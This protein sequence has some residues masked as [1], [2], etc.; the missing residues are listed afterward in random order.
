M[1]GLGMSAPNPL[2]STLRY[3]R[4]EYLDYVNIRFRS[5]LFEEEYGKDPV[6]I[7]DKKFEVEVG[8]TVLDVPREQ[9][10]YS[11]DVSF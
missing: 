3:F 6:T 1:Y 4:N 2:M 7:D 9:Y 5:D 8:K 11:D 10:W